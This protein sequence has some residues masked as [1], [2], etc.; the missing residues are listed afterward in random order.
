MIPDNKVNECFKK[1]AIPLREFLDGK[2]DENQLK[3]FVHMV[4]ATLIQVLSSLGADSQTIKKF[5][6]GCVD[7]LQS[8]K[9]K[10]EEDKP[11]L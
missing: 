11:C 2:P 9:Q 5:L 7:D 3:E 6:N 1:I 10:I 8:L 4:S